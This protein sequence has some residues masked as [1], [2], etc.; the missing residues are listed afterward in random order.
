MLSTLRIDS[1]NE[2]IEQIEEEL[3]GLRAELERKSEL[4][5]QFRQT[6]KMDALA[7]L[8]GGIAH[9]FNNI[10]QAVLGHTQ[11]A[12]MERAETDPI[13]NTLLQI[14]AIVN[15][16]CDLTK[17][18]LTFGR[19]VRSGFMSVDLNGKIGEIQQILQ[20]SL[21]KTIQIE[22]ALDKDLKKLCADP[23]QIEQILMNLG[24]NAKDAMPEG[25]RLRFKTEN[26]TL[27]RDHPLARLN[28]KPGE[29]VFLSVSDTGMGMDRETLQRIFEPFFSTKGKGKGAGLGLAMVYALVKNHDGLIECSSKPGVGT[30]FRLYFPAARSHESPAATENGKG[31]VQGGD[32]TLLLV[33]GEADVLGI[34]TKMLRNIG[35]NVLTASS[36]EEA[37]NA[38]RHAWEKIALV[39][40]DIG[41]PGM[42]SMKCLEELFSIDR[43]AKVIVSTGY[44]LNGRI[45]KTLELG[46]KDYLKKPYSL[47]CLLAKVR[48]V[49]DEELDTH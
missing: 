3:R 38:Y 45:K 49:L 18:F 48:S 31:K 44:S 33:D 40:L 13:Y 24:L 19:K 12:L 27:T 42:G 4:E 2:R 32:E 22:T 28:S 23:S 10:L 34:S 41:T 11:L 5:E 30:D 43:S 6:Q 46:A 36:G 16:G 21:P 15:K 20:R 8:A 39:I 29:Y 14:E 9:D 35:Y 25:G 26:V 7:N 17:Q 37:I 1:E 47:N